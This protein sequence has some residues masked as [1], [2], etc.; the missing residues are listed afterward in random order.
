MSDSDKSKKENEKIELDKDDIDAFDIVEETLDLDAL[1]VE[2][3]IEKEVSV[4]DSSGAPSLDV[5]S[6][7]GDDFDDFD[8]IEED[9]VATGPMASKVKKPSSKTPAFLGVLALLAAGGAGYYFMSQNASVSSSGTPVTPVLI[10][11][12]GVAVDENNM[13]SSLDVVINNNINEVGVAADDEG[14][15]LDIPQP[16]A[17]HSIKKDDVDTSNVL[18]DAVDDVSLTDLGGVSSPVPEENNVLKS[19][20]IEEDI[21]LVPEGLF[22]PEAPSIDDATLAVDVVESS[23]APEKIEE[24]ILSE[25]TV[26]DSAVDAVS[27]MEDL[28]NS[29]D[30][31]PVENSLS[32]APEQRK[33]LS[34]AVVSEPENAYFD[35]VQKINQQQNTLQSSGPSEVDPS[36]EPA[37]K[38]LIVTDSKP[39][40]SIEAQVQQARRALKLGRY[41]AA[42]QYYDSLYRKNPRDE[43][44]LMGR[45]VSLH[46]LGR[47]GAAINAYE[48]L[49]N[50][51]PKNADALVNM[52]GLV[53]S[54]YPAVALQ[55]LLSIRQNNPENPGVVAQIG[56]TYA[57]MKNYT[58]A[59]RYLDMAMNIEPNNALHAYNKAVVYDRQGEKKQAVEYYDRSLRLDAVHGGG[60]SVNRDAIYDR[61]SKLR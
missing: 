10:Q 9:L 2:L 22:M 17:F 29:S 54:Q 11:E 51:Y 12:S 59:H 4:V 18:S 33:V 50:R 58:D 26:I 24:N 38:Y 52:L 23:E 1:D 13:E 32:P 53:K 42:Y 20:V 15:L 34:K 28:V 19:E 56:L 36:I 37:S 57:G 35:S 45:A 14:L 41:D 3:D 40:T 30:N 6:D 60:R 39:S 47:E 48:D 21:A 25:D 49:L 61:L 8:D 16:E 44:I 7:T 43:S 5:S 27:S 55:K 46:K 31:A